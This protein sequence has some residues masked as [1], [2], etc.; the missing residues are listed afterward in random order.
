MYFENFSALISMDGH[1]PYVWSAYGVTAIVLV[2]LI[3]NPILRK[4]RFIMQQRMQLR[5]EEGHKQ[6]QAAVA[7]SSP[8]RG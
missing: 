1:G 3:I 6:G 4:R 2:L 8:S 7:P 5:R